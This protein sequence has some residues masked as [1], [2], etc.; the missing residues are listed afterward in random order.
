MAKGD[1]KKKGREQTLEESVSKLIASTASIEYDPATQ[2]DDAKGEQDEL[3]SASAISQSQP[4]VQQ[5]PKATL[6]N[7]IIKR[8]A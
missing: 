6:F 7:T 1:K 3:V 5:E 4:V 2:T 8:L